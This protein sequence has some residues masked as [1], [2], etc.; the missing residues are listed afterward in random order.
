MDRY[1]SLF[2]SVW[3]FSVLGVLFYLYLNLI[4]EKLLNRNKQIYKMF[5]E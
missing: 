1:H 3:Y 2:S 5:D 4:R